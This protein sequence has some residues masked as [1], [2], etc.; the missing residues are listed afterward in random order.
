MFPT[1]KQGKIG[2]SGN[3]RADPGIADCDNDIIMANS[4]TTNSLN[5]YFYY[6]LK[7]N[8]LQEVFS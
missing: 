1:I 5:L 4:L 6:L 7:Y 3:A 8:F 2:Q